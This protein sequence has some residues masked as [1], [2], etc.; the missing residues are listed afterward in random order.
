ML[1][2]VTL[3]GHLGGPAEIKPLEGGGKVARMNVATRR[4]WQDDKGEWRDRT[5][6]VRVVTF[7][8]GLIDRVIAEKAVKGAPVLLTGELRSNRYDD[9]DG[10]RHYV[11]EVHIGLKHEL[12]FP[13]RLPKDD[14]AT[15]ASGATGPGT[16]GPGMSD[17]GTS[18]GAEGDAGAPAT[19]AGG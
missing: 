19:A 6:W 1:N 16:S 5:A 3:Q 7:R 8:E 14:A 12:Q 10:N 17:P 4:A 9:K 13:P 15:A 18:D 2:H 11:L